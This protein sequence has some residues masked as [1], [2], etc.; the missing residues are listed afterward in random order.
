M[1]SEQHRFNQHGQVAAFVQIADMQRTRAC[2]RRWKLP[3]VSIPPGANP[4]STPSGVTVMRSG[5]MPYAVEIS[6]A[7]KRE[8]V[9]TCLAP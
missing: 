7:E 4:S 5:A 1:P 2:N 6:A 9:R 8:T 3:D